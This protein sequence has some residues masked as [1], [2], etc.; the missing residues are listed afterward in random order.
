[1]MCTY[2][3]SFGQ[4]RQRRY[5]VTLCSLHLSFSSKLAHEQRMTLVSQ[6]WLEIYWSSF[7]C[8]KKLW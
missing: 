6:E 8:W 7:C 5:S 3:V 2:Y 1:M 4:R